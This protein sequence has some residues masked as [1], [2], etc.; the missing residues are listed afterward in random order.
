MP[1]RIDY[2]QGHVNSQGEPAPW[3]IVNKDRDEVVGS[4]RSKEDAEASIRARLAAEHGGRLT[5]QRRSS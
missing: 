2:C 3:L 5:G 1:Y 4:S